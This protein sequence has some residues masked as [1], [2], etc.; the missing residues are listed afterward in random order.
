VSRVLRALVVGSLGACVEQS[1][2]HRLEFARSLDVDLPARFDH[3]LLEGVGTP[4]HVL[5]VN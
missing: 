5:G 1:F 2:K 4:D 3:D